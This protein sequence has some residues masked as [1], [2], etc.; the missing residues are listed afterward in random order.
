M[1]AMET[2]SC[3][4]NELLMVPYSKT[5]KS[6]EKLFFIFLNCVRTT[7]Q[8]FSRHGILHVFNMFSHLHQLIPSI[9]AI[10]VRCFIFWHFSLL[11]ANFYLKYTLPNADKMNCCCVFW[12]QFNSSLVRGENNTRC[13]K[14]F[15]HIW[16]KIHLKSRP[17]KPGQWFVDFQ[18]D[19][20]FIQCTTESAHLQKT[21][22]TDRFLSISV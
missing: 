7:S 11:H 13:N 3:L 14:L 15:C 18:D 10:H 22:D 20:L 5:N 17:V 12:I 4:Q 1:S 16:I 8:T 21:K 9:F 19:T 6:N 2:Y